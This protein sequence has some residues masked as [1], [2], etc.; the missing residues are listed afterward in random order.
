MNRTELIGMLSAYDANG[1]QHEFTVVRITKK[2]VI[3][4]SVYLDGDTIADH[5]THAGATRVIIKYI[6]H[7]GWTRHGGKK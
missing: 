4:H 7:E 5:L 6:Q 2:D 3:H 1:L